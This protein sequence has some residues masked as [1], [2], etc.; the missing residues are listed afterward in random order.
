ME[1]I[2]NIK[3]LY[4]GKLRTEPGNSWLILEAATSLGLKHAAQGPIKLRGNSLESLG[5]LSPDSK[6]H[7]TFQLDWG[8]ELIQIQEL[9]D[10]YPETNSGL[11]KR[12]AFG[13]WRDYQIGIVHLFNHEYIEWCIENVDDFYSKYM[14]DN[15][16]A[17]NKYGVFPKRVKGYLKQ[18][19]NP[20]ITPVF[21]EW[22]SIQQY[23][24]EVGYA[25]KFQYQI[26]C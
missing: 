16:D 13:R 1:E 19:N 25:R 2:S 10:I 22:K 24:K 17:F 9:N 5:V 23:A 18:S 3:C 8:L 14:H 20:S 4:Q 12:L 7:D 11:N 15:I 6:F 21:K 26:E